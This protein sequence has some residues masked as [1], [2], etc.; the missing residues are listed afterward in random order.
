MLPHLNN[1][2]L[3]DTQ[4]PGALTEV[5]TYRAKIPP[6]SV[7]FKAMTESGNS[8]LEL[9]LVTFNEGLLK[10]VNNKL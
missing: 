3:W 10:D 4:K 2:N 5:F 8:P 6:K 1:Y 9:P 7:L